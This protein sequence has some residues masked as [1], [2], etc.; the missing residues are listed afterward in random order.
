MQYDGNL[1]EGESH[2]A[3]GHLESLAERVPRISP[4]EKRADNRNRR[5]GGWLREF[6]TRRALSSCREWG[7]D[8]S[9]LGQ[10]P[11]TG[12]VKAVEEAAIHS[13]VIF[14]NPTL[15]QRRQMAAWIQGLSYGCSG[16]ERVS[17]ASQSGKAQN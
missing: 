6:P 16:K 9:G 14:P 3:E 13:S 4:G 1:K 5:R 11:Q 2:I 8:D 17:G 10:L 7:R 15:R 12:R